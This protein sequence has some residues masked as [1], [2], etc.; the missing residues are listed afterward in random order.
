MGARSHRYTSKVDLS[1]LE[2]TRK[3]G[4]FSLVDFVYGVFWTRKG[5]P[6]LN[7][8]QSFSMFR[9]KRGLKK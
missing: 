1:L 4:R 7:I 3:R 2:R 9:E 6:S 8:V 5:K